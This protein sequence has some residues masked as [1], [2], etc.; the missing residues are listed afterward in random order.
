[1][2]LLPSLAFMTVLGAFG[3]A[4]AID[5][6]REPVVPPATPAA[7]AAKAA[8]VAPAPAAPAAAA[9]A[10]VAPAPV[11]V[12]ESAGRP[13]VPKPAIVRPPAVAAPVK[14]EH[15]PV[16]QPDPKSSPR[17]VPKPASLVAQMPRFV[18]GDTWQYIRTPTAGADRKVTEFRTTLASVDER[19]LATASGY[20]MTPFLAA[21]NQTQNNRQTRLLRPHG[22][23]MQFPLA[24]GKAW[25]DAYESVVT[26]GEPRIVSRIKARA[27][28][29]RRETTT[30]PA[31]EF[32]TLVVQHTQEIE[33]TKGGRESGTRTVWY[34]PDAR[35]FVRSRY[36]RRDLTS[37]NVL[38]AW[39]LELKSF[40]VAR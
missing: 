18:V 29:L 12:P 26:P 32:D 39:T 28:V 20:R 16:A 36:E 4:G 27:R 30:V 35:N 25:T 37:G 13:S 5:I 1:M 17:P 10:T 7:P 3:S 40:S 19:E 2:G 15:K 22:L 6:V 8:P 24:E 33:P 34:S 21:L 23:S 38:E 9:P 14:P 11:P 31:G